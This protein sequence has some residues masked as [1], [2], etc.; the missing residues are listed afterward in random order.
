[1]SGD[2]TGNLKDLSEIGRLLKQDLGGSLTFNAHLTAKEQQALVLNAE[3]Y[4][5]KTPY[6][7]VDE[8]NLRSDLNNVLQSPYGSMNLMLDSL[9][10]K[11][12]TLDEFT[13]TANGTQ[14]A[15]FFESQGEGSWHNA[16]QYTANG[17]ISR[18]ANEL[19]MGVNTFRE[20]CRRADSPQSAV[21]LFPEWKHSTLFVV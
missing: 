5:I 2:V 15:M 19:T 13:L 1:M 6:A 8:L 20:P 11:D 4:Q 16:F 12:L 7:Q 9:R 10:T 21:Q 3:G 17:N 18:N 14:Q